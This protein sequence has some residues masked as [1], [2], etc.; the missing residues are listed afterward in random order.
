MNNRRKLVIALGAGALT[1]PFVSFAQQQGKVWRIGF[2]GADAA[3]ARALYSEAFRA[4]LRDFGYEEGKNIVMESRWA[5]GKYDRLPDLVADLV[6]LKVDVIVTYGTPGSRAAKQ[7]TTTIPIVLANLGDPIA[8]GVVTNLARPGG[9]I[10]GSTYFALELYA[11]RLELLRDAFPR[12]RQIAFLVNPDNSSIGPILHEMEG[13]ARSLK[14]EL[15]RFDARRPL[16]LDGA[17]S[18]MTR[19]RA[20]AVVIHQD[21]MFV[22]NIKAVCDLAAKNRLASIGFVESVDAG[23]LM[24]YGA[25]N[26]ALWRRAAYFIDKILK[27]T[28]PGDIP[29]ERATRF[30]LIVNMKTA[31]AIGTKIPQSILF[32]ADKV[33]E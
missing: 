23:C 29:I 18:A 11:K 33:I 5:D 7:A 24:G 25:D 22:G 31:K 17:F 32:R 1:A 8:S 26:I 9:N 15:R 20:G 13:A 27:G 19:S 14:L 21:A 12:I 10:T 6:R 30:E 4:G 3:P 28:R 16:E 2:L